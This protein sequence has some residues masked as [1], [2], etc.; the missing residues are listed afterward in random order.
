MSSV[1]PRWPPPR[2]PRPAALASPRRP[3]Y[4]YLLAAVVTARPR[5][6]PAAAA[7]RRRGLAPRGPGPRRRR[8]ARPGDRFRG[9]RVARRRRPLLP[10]RG[11]RRLR[12]HP[13]PD[14]R[15]LGPPHR[16]PE[17]HHDDLGP[18]A[19]GPAQLLP[20]PAAQHHPGLRRRPGRR[21]GQGRH[22][23]WR[24]TPAQPIAAGHDFRWRSR[25]TASPATSPT[26]TAGTPGRAPVRSGWSRASRRAPR[27]GSPRTTTPPTRR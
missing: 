20:R 23:N 13:L 27:G 18:L 7:R 11:Q 12:R 2:G 1:D 4:V 10:R 6:V 21:P 17:R 3:A 14:R 8:P 26:S 19:P 9:R 25:T 22:A 16:G 15:Q 24:V 5:R